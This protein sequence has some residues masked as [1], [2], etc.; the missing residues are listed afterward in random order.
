VLR[1]KWLND[2][3]FTIGQKITVA[4]ENKKLVITPA[5]STSNAILFNEQ[6]STPATS[7]NTPL[8]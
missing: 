2:A 5:I 3:G 4:I 7:A 1:G 8:E 6:V